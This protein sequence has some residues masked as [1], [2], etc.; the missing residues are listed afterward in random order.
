MEFVVINDT[1]L[2]T[3]YGLGL[4][5]YSVGAPVPD[6]KLID[7]PGRAGKLDASLALNGKL[8]LK[9]R[10]ITITLR[11]RNADFADFHKTL[12]A[13]TTLINGAEESRVVFSTDP[14]WYYKGRFLVSYSK[15]NAV[16][17]QITLTCANAFPYK[18]DNSKTTCNFGDVDMTDLTTFMACNTRLYQGTN[19]VTF[20]G[21]EYNGPVT[22]YTGMQL[23][24]TWNGTTYQLINGKNYI[25]EIHFE[26]GENILTFTAPYSTYVRVVYERG[27]Q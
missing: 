18:I 13:V 15:T 4:L 24:V 5:D 6:I 26:E 23:S 10:P 20:I 25:P 22:I 17:G 16:T 27:I 21:Y 2:L 14:E 7:I 8:N 11:T 9:S 3:N 1:N 19:E 12:T